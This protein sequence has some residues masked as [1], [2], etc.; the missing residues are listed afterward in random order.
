MVGGTLADGKVALSLHE[1]LEG[2]LQQQPAASQQH[3]EDTSGAQR[4]SF[5]PYHSQSVPKPE[6]LEAH[7]NVRASA[8]KPVTT[9]MLRNIPN[10]YTQNTLLQEVDEIG[11]AGSYDFF[12]LPMDVH[13]R[14]NVG[15][16]FINFVAP[17]DAEAFRRTF[18]EHR[19]RKFQ[20][21]KI[22]S[23]C[24]AHVQGL[25]ENLRHFE[26][27]AVTHARNDQYRPIVLRGNKRVD[28][29]EAVADA[30][31]RTISMASTASG[32]SASSGGRSRG[33]AGGGGGRQERRQQQ[34]RGQL[35]GQAA[36]GNSG[37]GAGG[38]SGG[39]SRAALAK[40]VV[41]GSDV[42]PSGAKNH[43]LVPPQGARHGLEKAIRD[44]LSTC[45]QS[46]QAPG[47]VSPE[48]AATYLQALSDP[49][50]GIAPPATVAGMPALPPGLLSPVQDKGFVE[51]SPP[52]EVTQLMSLRSLLVDRLHAVGGPTCLT[53][54]PPHPEFVNSTAPDASGVGI[55]AYVHVPTTSTSCSDAPRSFDGKCQEMASS[56]FNGKVTPRTS[57]LFLGTA[58]DTLLPDSPELLL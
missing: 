18:S 5:Q 3:E 53:A 9:M 12:Y 20:S 40:S 11:F 31:A 43:R 16:A 49:D 28:F 39:H 45:Q 21:R 10:K 56:R 52:G 26:N 17:E 57:N 29:E 44:L 34:Q 54:Q 47:A 2:A 33:E 13:N 30:R 36:S 15:Y 48:L 41:P 58:M 55:P 8:G 6:N 4:R 35:A 27:R 42:P 14:S 7:A 37:N 1:M 19:F 46:I 23:V 38:G 24:T 51:M 32:A 25:Y 50:M 22:S